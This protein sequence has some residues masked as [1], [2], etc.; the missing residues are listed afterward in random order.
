LIE[1]VA[2]TEE[3]VKIEG[4]TTTGILTTVTGIL[5]YDDLRQGQQLFNLLL[6]ISQRTCGVLGSAFFFSR[7][8]A[9]FQKGKV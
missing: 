3:K 2:L 7:S 1:E 9:E 4:N 5:L 8:C 6:F